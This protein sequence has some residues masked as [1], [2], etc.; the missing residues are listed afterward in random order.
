MVMKMTKIKKKKETIPKT[1][2]EEETADVVQKRAHREVFLDYGPYLVI[3]IVVI[4]IRTFIATPI[5]VNGASM[6]PTL[7]NGETMILNKLVVRVRGIERWDIVVARTDGSNVIKR[8]IGLPGERIKYQDGI[9][10]INGE[11]IEDPFSLTFTYDFEERRIGSNEY[12]LM[13]DNRS[14][15]QDSRNPVI[16]NVNRRDIRGRTNIILFPFNRFG[17]VD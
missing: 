9:L 7:T 14:N 17:S 4:V 8:V 3:I 5:R 12:F 15:S 6:D 2:L 13:G 11:A 1:I 16:G 10:F